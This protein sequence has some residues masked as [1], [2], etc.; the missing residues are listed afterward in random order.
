MKMPSMQQIYKIVA[1][2]FF[3]SALCSVGNIIYTWNLTNAFIK[4]NYSVGV[5]INLLIGYGIL[6]S[7]KTIPVASLN[8]NDFDM[9]LQS[10]KEA[11]NETIPKK[12][13]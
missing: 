12:G 11:K 5:I 8:D 3:F 6:L 13:S 2:L 7:S 4:T 10:A 9:I 1:Y